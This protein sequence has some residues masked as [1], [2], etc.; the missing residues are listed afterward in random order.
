MS[1]RILII[2]LIKLQFNNLREC[3]LLLSGLF[4]EEKVYC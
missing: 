4:D 3:S 1:E 2:Q